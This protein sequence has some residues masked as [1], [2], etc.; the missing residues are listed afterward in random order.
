MD[1]LTKDRLGS[2]LIINALGDRIDESDGRFCGS[3]CGGKCRRAAYDRACREATELAAKLGAGWK[4]RVWENLG[5]HYEA[6]KGSPTVAEVSV[7]RSG[8]RRDGDWTVDGYYGEITRPKQIFSD[9]EEG[10]NPHQFSA[11]L[12]ADPRE[13]FHSALVNANEFCEELKAA[14]DEAVS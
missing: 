12:F 5:W 7:S 4:G 13:A 2:G 9:R 10:G 11:K 14:L 3:G 1:T 6:V 8:G